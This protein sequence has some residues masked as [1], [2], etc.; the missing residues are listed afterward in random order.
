MAQEKSMSLI[1]HLTELRKVLI[2]SAY[3]IAVG[4]VIGWLV[5]EPLFG[6]LTK[7]VA[8]LAGTK[9]VTTTITEPVMVKLKVAV[10]A[11]ILLAIPVVSWQIWSF[12]LPALKNNERKYVYIVVPCSILLFIGGAA[13]AFYVVLP[14][15]LKF[16]LFVSSG[17]SYTPLI[18]QSSYLSFL[19]TFLLAFG[20]VFELPVVLLILVRMGIITPQWLSKNRRY[21][22]FFIVVAAAIFSPTP[23]IPSLLLMSAPMYLLYEISIWLSYIVAKRR[24]KALEGK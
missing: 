3:A 1:E 9:F 8:T 17:V 19:L 24:K 15:G 6:Y 18:T 20:A 2:V 23:D 10:L 4:A 5:S 14:I 11:G 12:V 13:F 21:A 16:L 22:I 7:P